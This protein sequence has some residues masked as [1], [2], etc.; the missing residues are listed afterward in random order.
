MVN[1]RIMEESGKW[2]MEEKRKVDS[3]SLSLQEQIL[4]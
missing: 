2:I 4:Y 3:G 1:K